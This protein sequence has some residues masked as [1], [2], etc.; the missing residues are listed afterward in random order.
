MPTFSKGTSFRTSLRKFRA[1]YINTCLSREM[2]YNKGSNCI[3]TITQIQDKY[4]PIYQLY[5]HTRVGARQ[6]PTPV[7]APC[8]CQGTN[9]ALQPTNSSPPVKSEPP[10]DPAH[11]KADTSHRL[12]RMPIDLPS[13]AMH[14][15]TSTWSIS[16][17]A[18]F[19]RANFT[20]QVM[21]NLVNEC[22]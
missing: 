6:S 9:M 20:V 18:H 12:P 21:Y 2:S 14:R 1:V 5:H 7:S 13:P 11:T 4:L 19:S 8:A 22:Q 15:L 17:C 10:S 16:V 3:M